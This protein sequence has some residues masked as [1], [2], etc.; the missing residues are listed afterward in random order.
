MQNANTILTRIE[1]IQEN[2]AALQAGQPAGKTMHECVKELR[3]ILD[4]NEGLWE[5]C[6]EFIEMRDHMNTF[7]RMVN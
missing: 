6:P 7:I 4:E 2:I 3:T 5:T 1:N